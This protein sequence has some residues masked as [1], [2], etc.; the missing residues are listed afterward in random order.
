MMALIQSKY[1]IKE[2]HFEGYEYTAAAA[3]W[4]DKIQQNEDH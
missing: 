3:K 2:W 1:N 4:H